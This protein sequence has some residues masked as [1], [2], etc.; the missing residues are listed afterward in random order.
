MA[1]YSGLIFSALF[2]YA[3]LIASIK[4]LFTALSPITP[5]G[6]ICHY[7]LFFVVRA[8]K[9]PASQKIDKEQQCAVVARSQ[10]RIALC[11]RINKYLI[12]L[13]FSSYNGLQSRTLSTFGANQAGQPQSNQDDETGGGV[14]PERLDL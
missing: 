7:V 1:F 13:I 10:Q 12:P 4:I 9:P 6:A 8:A 3:F 14:D 11:L 2:Q 5:Y